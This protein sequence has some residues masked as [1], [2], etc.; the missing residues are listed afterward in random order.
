MP[1]GHTLARLA[2]QF[3]TVFS[4]QALV[5]SSP[6]GRFAEGAAQLTG[7][8]LI[9]VFAVGKQMF[10]E[11]DAGLYLRVHL[12]LY[13]QFTFGGDS[14]FLTHSL[15]SSARDPQ[16]QK[17]TPA[18]ESQS[19]PGRE[20]HAVC[21]VGFVSYVRPPDP[22]GAVRLRVESAHGW[23]DLRG[24]TACEVLGAA[25]VA[26]ILSQL[27][28]DPIHDSGRA[29][30]ERFVAKV[31]ALGKG[32]GMQLMNQTVISGVGNVY[33]AE[34]L[35]IL[36]I[37]PYAPGSSLEDF[38][39]R[40]LWA[41]AAKLMR[42]GVHD[43][44][45]ITTSPRMWRHRTSGRA[46]QRNADGLIRNSSGTAQSRQSITA[47]YPPEELAR[48]VYRRQGMPCRVC[49]STVVLEELAARKLYYCPECQ[50]RPS[51][52]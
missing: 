12:G 6:Q 35:F 36:G 41:L 1:E 39:L 46:A 20:M 50:R 24:P 26:D 25:Q 13:G 43:G 2:E 3:D 8:T 5:C 14:W 19:E 29:A 28:P 31:R 23:L 44:R 38:R 34:L 27:G 30:Q 33:R 9:A 17:A 40:E 21:E 45:I 22:V 15:I 10:F 49:G 16:R 52:E 48:Y 51:G 47:S 4:G 42:Y 18:S 37:D 7:H 11:F 32:I